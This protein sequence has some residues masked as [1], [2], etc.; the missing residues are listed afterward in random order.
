MASPASPRGAEK[1]ARVADLSSIDGVAEVPSG[2]YKPQVD[3]RRFQQL[4][5][6]EESRH[7]GPNFPPNFPS[8][9]GLM[10]G[11]PTK[12][13]SV[14]SNDT[15]LCP[16][17]P[18]EVVGNRHVVAGGVP[19]RG[20]KGQLVEREK[21]GGSA[22]CDDSADSLHNVVERHR[23]GAGRGHVESMM[24][25]SELSCIPL[26]H[27][28]SREDATS[29][30]SQVSHLQPSNP[31]PRSRPLVLEERRLPGDRRDGRGQLNPGRTKEE[32]EEEGTLMSTNTSKIHADLSRLE[33]VSHCYGGLVKLY[34]W[35][36]FLR[37][38]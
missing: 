24:G 33:Q 6:E 19:A 20:G 35:L 30:S 15:P 31:I 5:E 2:E 18:E 29:L 36:F 3:L 7:G 8:G 38:L 12:L 21:R 1:S 22:W 25:A 13:S 4:L 23:A 27:I 17:G 28:R 26:D 9:G 16:R 37:G 11:L 10:G 34:K 14:A 32:E